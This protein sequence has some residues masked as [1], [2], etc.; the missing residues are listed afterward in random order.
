M[1][2]AVKFL[3]KG[4]T[5]CPI[6][7][8]KPQIFLF[9]LLRCKCCMWAKSFDANVWL[10]LT[11]IATI[12]PLKDSITRSISSPVCVLS[13]SIEL[14]CA[15]LSSAWARGHKVCISILPDKDSDSLGKLNTLADPVKTNCPAVL[16][17]S[18]IY[19]MEANKEGAFCTSSIMM[20]PGCDVKNPKGSLLTKFRIDQ[21]SRV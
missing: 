16:F 13:W 14:P 19:L 12:S 3:A 11:S 6:Y 4:I 1:G 9:A 2:S 5:S 21:S 10:L 18:T 17:L 15:W 8:T 20:G 7:T